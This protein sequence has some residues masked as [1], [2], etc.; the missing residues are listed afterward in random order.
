MFCRDHSGIQGLDSL[1]CFQRASLFESGTVGQY[2]RSMN[3]TEESEDGQSR[4][5]ETDDDFS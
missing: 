1:I 4:D 2:L 3:P 5:E